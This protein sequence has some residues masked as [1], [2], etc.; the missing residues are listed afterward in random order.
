MTFYDFQ[1]KIV[2]SKHTCCVT[3]IKGKTA[4][5]FRNLVIFLY[6]VQD[7]LIIFPYYS[8]TNEGSFSLQAVPNFDSTFF[9]MI[10]EIP[11]W[12]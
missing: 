7:I 1:H 10:I 11:V 2:I 3:K 5:M 4:N 6:C 12:P 9:I 8:V